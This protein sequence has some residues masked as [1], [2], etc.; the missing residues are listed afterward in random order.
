M[1]GFFEMQSVDG[2]LAES[3]GAGGQSMGFPAYLYCC[4][5]SKGTEEE[6]PARVRIPSPSYPNIS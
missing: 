4:Q 6:K 1:L 5:N 2:K 3:K